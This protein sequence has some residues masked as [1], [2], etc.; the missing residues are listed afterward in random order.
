M[1]K[2]GNNQCTGLTRM[3]IYA[4]KCRPIHI[5]SIPGAAVISEV[6]LPSF[7]INQILSEY[8]NR[9]TGTVDLIAR[10][11]ALYTA[12]RRAAA[13]PQAAR[14]TRPKGTRSPHRTRRTHRNSRSTRSYTATM[15]TRWILLRAQQWC[16]AT[17]M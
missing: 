4:I 5:I 9:H 1:S 16:V 15:Q 13:C 8:N 2:G 3:T 10:R 12:R 7:V 6:G 17:P 14:E 11:R